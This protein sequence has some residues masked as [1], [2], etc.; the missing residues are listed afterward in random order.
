MAKTMKWDPAEKARLLGFA[1][2]LSD[3]WVLTHEG[4]AA[5]D[6]AAGAGIT[7]ALLKSAGAPA[8]VLTSLRRAGVR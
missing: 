6:A 3:V 1:Q 8:H 7:L 4:A 5:R 2:A